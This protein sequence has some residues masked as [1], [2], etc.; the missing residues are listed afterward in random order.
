M[1]FEPLSGMDAGFL[2]METPT[3]HMHTLKVAVM[4][5]SMIKIMVIKKIMVKVIKKEY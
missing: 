3:L 5:M 4:Q 2:Y 1:R